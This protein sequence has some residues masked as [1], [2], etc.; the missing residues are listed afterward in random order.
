MRVARAA[1]EL[2]RTSGSDEESAAAPLASPRELLRRSLERVD[3]EEDDPMR[4]VW[5][6]LTEL[7]QGVLRAVAWNAA[8]RTA[9]ETL[10]RFGLGHSGTA[11]NTALALEKRG[12]L[13]KAQSTAGFAFDSPFAR[14]WVVRPPG[15]PA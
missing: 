1:Y 10:E 5:D 11:R 2:A 6:N 3:A 13:R 7:Q 15:R 9:R 4:V 12:L 14:V 8:G